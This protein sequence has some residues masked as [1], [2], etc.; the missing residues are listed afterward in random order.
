MLLEKE[1][2]VTLPTHEETSADLARTLPVAD[3]VLLGLDLRLNRV[4]L[5]QLQELE[6]L[7][8]H[9]P[10]VAEVEFGQD[11]VDFLLGQLAGAL[12]EQL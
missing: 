4:K 11:I 10:I 2:L 3:P 5:L 6:A 8:L 12:G 9:D 7:E 1:V